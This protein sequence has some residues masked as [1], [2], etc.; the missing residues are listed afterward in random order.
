[1]SDPTNNDPHAPVPRLGG[2]TNTDDPGK[3]LTQ[4][5]SPAIAPGSADLADGHAAKADAPEPATPH[6]RPNRA[7]PGP[8]RGLGT[9][10][11]LAPPRPS[12]A[13]ETQPQAPAA[14]PA[15]RLRSIA[16]LVAA[17]ALLGGAAG[18]LATTALSR[19]SAS[20]AE[21]PPYYA[22][23]TEALGRVDRELTTVKTGIES[24]KA[25]GQQVVRLAERVERTEKVQADA[26]TKINKAIDSIDRVERRMV[27]AASGD[28]TGAI[29]E[30]HAAIMAPPAAG[31][32]MKRLAPSPMAGPIVEGWV[33]R[34]VY[35]G[36]AM[37]QGRA[38]I[39]QVIPGDN[40]PGLGR[41]EQVRR[42]DGR[43]IVV[44][45]RGVI[46]SR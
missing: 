4:V 25:T 10:L 17:A 24:A 30:P 13:P 9:A 26:G 5:E 8:T 40:F 35:N 16:A 31:P 32:D 46:V 38:G 45:S 27:A 22:A 1:M 28:V 23:V 29:T 6:G 20:P 11:I 37:I 43:W 14:A 42:Q 21:T 41:I 18:A 19:L 12:D 3:P 44:T 36:A 7:E 34:D 15:F 33:V 2:D 39:I